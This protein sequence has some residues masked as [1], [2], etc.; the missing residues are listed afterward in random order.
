M[1]QNA[2]SG[3]VFQYLPDG[4]YSILFNTYWSNPEHRWLDADFATNR[5]NFTNNL[6]LNTDSAGNPIQQNPTA[7]SWVQTTT[8]TWSIET[9]ETDFPL[10]FSRTFDFEPGFMDLENQDYN[11]R[12]D[13]QSI[14]AGAH[15][16]HAVGSG[17]N[18]KT[19]TVQDST[20]FF[21]GWE[22]QERGVLPDQLQIGSNAPVRIASIDYDT[23]VITL[24]E[25]ITYQDGDGVSLPY[26]GS[27]PDL[28][29]RE[30]VPAPVA[31][32]VAAPAAP[33]QGT[34]P[35]GST[36]IKP[37]VSGASTFV[38]LFSVAAWIAFLI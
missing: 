18:T 30:F 10:V 25:S 27:A 35:G 17:D 23:H 19:I 28:G 12:P 5:A 24:E 33:V 16:T 2:W 36:P 26:A 4:N 21:S 20:F 11:L 32:P 14:D 6:I 37:T 38:P 1:Y 9:L 15:L 34:T 7:V 8:Y 13:S 29:P 3:D 22:F 31:A